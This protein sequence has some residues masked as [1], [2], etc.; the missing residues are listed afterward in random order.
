MKKLIITL[1]L[2]L[3]AA[4]AGAQGT[5]GQIQQNTVAYS[6][7]QKSNI[8]CNGYCSFWWAVTRTQWA[9]DKGYYYF[10]VWFYSNSLYNDGT[11]AWTRVWNVTL[12]INGSAFTTMD[13]IVFQKEYAPAALRFKI[14]TPTPSIHLGWGGFT[15]W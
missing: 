8:G 1:S 9:D 6:T 12:T 11:W 2:V 4:L 13:Q 5:K 3:C 15:R 10:Y 7:W 14:K